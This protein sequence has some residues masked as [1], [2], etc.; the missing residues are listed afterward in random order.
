MGFG[1]EDLR[2][3]NPR[4][5]YAVGTGFGLEG[6]IRA[7]GRTGRPGPGHERCDAPPRGFADPA[8][9][10]PHRARGLRRRH[11]PDAG[12][13]ARAAAPRED[14][15]GTTG[16][17]LALQLDARDADAGSSD[18]DDAGPRAQLGRHAAVGGVR[19]YRRRHR[20]GGCVQGEPAARHLRRARNRRSLRR[21]PV[22]HA[23]AAESSTVRS[24]RPSSGTASPAA[25]PPTGWSG[26]AASTS[27]ARR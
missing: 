9:R 11:A 15:R 24:C 27:C 17:G 16:R 2:R 18:V 14:R 4:I 6:P 19:D 26:S 13:P 21:R 20:H 1:Y 23:G 12:H 8:L 22:R 5:I 10:L 3:I 25:P 7:Q